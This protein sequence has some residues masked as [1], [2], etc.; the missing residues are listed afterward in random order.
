M[1]QIYESLNIKTKMCFFILIYNP[2]PLHTS[3]DIFALAIVYWLIISRQKLHHQVKIINS[4]QN[5]VDLK[6][7]YS[8]LYGRERKRYIVDIKLPREIKNL[9]NFIFEFC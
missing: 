5:S 9:I 8:N 7:H 2:N 4:S 3:N 6:D 1:R